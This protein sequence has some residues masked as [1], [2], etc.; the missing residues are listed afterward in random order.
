MKNKL[1]RAFKEVKKAVKDIINISQ[2]V[3]VS[4]RTRVVSGIVLAGLGMG[5]IVSGYIPLPAE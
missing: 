1:K 4:S 3:L 2:K 5:L